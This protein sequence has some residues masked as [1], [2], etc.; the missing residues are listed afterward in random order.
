MQMLAGALRTLTSERCALVGGHTSE[1]AEPALGLSVTGV[2][3]PDC[4]L[5]KGPLPL[6][7]VLVLTKGL[8]T[9]TIMAADMR[10]RAK[11]RWVSSAIDSMLQSNGPAAPLLHAHGCTACTD[12]TGF[13]FLGHLLEMVQ[14]GEQRAE[15]DDEGNSVVSDMDSDSASTAKIVRVPLTAVKLSLSS[16]PLLVGAADCVRMGVLSSLHP[17]VR[18]TAVGTSVVSAH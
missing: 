17:Q 2:V 10:G 15:V 6:G 13:G 14:F 9:G 11:G 12:V 18:G 16:V 8:G 1:G 5:R 3:R 4:V 7:N